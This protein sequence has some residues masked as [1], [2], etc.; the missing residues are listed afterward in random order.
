MDMQASDDDLP[1]PIHAPDPRRLPGPEGELYRRQVRAQVL[2][3]LCEDVNAERRAE[4]AREI[5]VLGADSMPALARAAASRHENAAALARSLIRL[6][7]PDEIG[8]QIY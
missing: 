8:R 5:L 4:I 2:M 7:A 3:D 1:L 6:L